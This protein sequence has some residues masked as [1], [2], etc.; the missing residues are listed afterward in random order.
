MT[1]LNSSIK[2][3]IMPVKKYLH[4]AI[5]VSD[6][7]KS[8]QFYSQVLGLGKVELPLNF[9]GI[10]YNIGEFQIH[11]IQAENVIKDQIDHP[12]WGRNRHLAFS[13]DNLETAKQQLITYNCSFQM[14]ASGRAALFT[15]DPDGNIIELNEA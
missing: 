13:V 11:L 7:E 12:K 10:L 1:H 9:P 8:E 4:A 6:L 2:V 15:K 5:L 14:S 3:Y